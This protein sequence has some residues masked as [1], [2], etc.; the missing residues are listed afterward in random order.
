MDKPPSIKL[1]ERFWFGSTVLWSVATRLAWDRVQNS[2]ASRLGDAA[3]TDGQIALVAAYAQWI[4]IAL[5]LLATVALWYLVARRASAIGKWLV[6][7]VAAWSGVRVLLTVFTML[8]SANP[9][10]L[11]QGGFL[12]AAALTIA[13]AAMLFRDDARAWFGEFDTDADDEE[14]PA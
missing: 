12:L 4:N 3:R 9:H 11:S 1:F 5:V 13:S 7:A 6:V 8:T 14:Q 2:V 10:P